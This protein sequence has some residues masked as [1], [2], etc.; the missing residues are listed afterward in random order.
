GPDE[1]AAG[2]P[3]AKGMNDNE[4]D[5]VR[6]DHSIPEVRGM[7]FPVPAGGGPKLPVMVGEKG[8]Y[9]CT[10]RVHGTPGHA[11]MPLR[12][13]NALVTA[14]EVVK[15]IADFQPKTEIH[16][17]WRAFVE[18]MQFS[19]DMGKALLDPDAFQQLSENL[20]VGLARM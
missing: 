5:A 10:I 8:T 11:S 9:W 18:R 7:A 17:V 20:P 2:Q 12:T 6:A 3:A 4:P 13:D 14:A 19:E 15:R 1:E 16:D